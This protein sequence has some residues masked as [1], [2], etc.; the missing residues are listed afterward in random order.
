[1]NALDIAGLLRRLDDAQVDYVLIGAVAL[2][3]HGPVR[4]T[5]DLDL[6]PGPDPE[7]LRR[8]G[9]LLV[10]LG[11][12][13]PAADARG[14]GNEDRA[15]L[16]RG[17]SLTLETALGGLD[18]VQRAEGV[19]SYTELATEALALDVFGVTARVCSRRHLRKMKLSRASHRD[20]ADVEDLDAI[21]D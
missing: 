13:L 21:G 4:S 14:F 1:M 6:V 3:A 9:N 19:P 12:Q 20:L 17:E 16:A 10:D 7:N 18:V 8:L 2:A 15:A 5:E 11:A